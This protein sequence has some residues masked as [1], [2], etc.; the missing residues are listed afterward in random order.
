MG[1]FWEQV[2]FKVQ[3]EIHD[4]AD[5]LNETQI[6]LGIFGFACIGMLGCEVVPN[7]AN[8]GCQ[9]GFEIP[10][11]LPPTWHKKRRF[12]PYKIAPCEGN[13]CSSGQIHPRGKLTPGTHEKNKCE[14]HLLDNHLQTRGEEWPLGECD[15][16][17]VP[18]P[19]DSCNTFPIQ[20]FHKKVLNCIQISSYRSPC[21][22]KRAQNLKSWIRGLR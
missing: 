8:L 10:S 20:S 5:S 12:F 3:V 6:N 11:P 7:D 16:V 13:I 2:W 19:L 15:P 17:L 18:G 21:Q 22:A 4:S 1:G 9:L 14:R